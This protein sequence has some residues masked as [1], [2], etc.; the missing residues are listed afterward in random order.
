MEAI[1]MLEKQEQI[2]KYIA[3]AADEAGLSEI[4][5][6]AAD[7]IEKATKV[8]RQRLSDAQAS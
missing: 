4:V 1:D 8:I 2:L 7:S 6:Q 3:C 5:D